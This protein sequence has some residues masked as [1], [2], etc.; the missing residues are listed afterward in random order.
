MVG[1][2]LA[3]FRS[4]AS[5]PNGSCRISPAL[6]TQT[7]GTTCAR[8]SRTIHSYF[9]PDNEDLKHAPERVELD[10]SRGL[11][12]VPGDQ[13]EL[14]H[15]LQMHAHSPTTSFDF[16]PFSLAHGDTHEND[17]CWYCVN[18]F[19]AE[20]GEEEHYEKSVES[21]TCAPSDL[22]PEEWDAYQFELIN[23]TDILRSLILH[24]NA[25]WL[26]DL[27]HDRLNVW[28]T[29]GKH[30]EPITFRIC[31]KDRFFN[32]EDT[33]VS[34]H[35]ES[36]WNLL[37]TWGIPELPYQHDMIYVVTFHVERTI[38]LFGDREVT[39]REL[40]EVCIGRPGRAAI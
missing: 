20:D 28:T 27:R 17:V 29:F 5:M 37:D 1:A 38:N 34:V 21:C 26:D 14:T 3:I 40:R 31:C 10:W 19:E 15:I 32:V 33:D 8:H 9:F 2:A 7:R 12:D 6:A 30:A 35:A 25:A 23:R 11:H 16:V 13:H 4:D 22:D 36:A 18:E 24:N 39:S